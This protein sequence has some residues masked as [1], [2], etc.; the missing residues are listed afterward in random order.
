[1]RGYSIPRSI[2]KID[3][4]TPCGWVA[5]VATDKAFALYAAICNSNPSA[6]EEQLPNGF[7]QTQMRDWQNYLARSVT[8]VTMDETTPQM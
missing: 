3:F 1:M 6:Y 4:R 8:M 5:T 7:H 2:G